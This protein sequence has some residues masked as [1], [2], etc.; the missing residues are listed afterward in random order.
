MRLSVS[1]RAVDIMGVAVFPQNFVDLTSRR[2]EPGE[3]G[4]VHFNEQC[5]GAVGTGE[6][7]FGPPKG[8]DLGTLDIQ[9]DH[10]R[11]GKSTFVHQT[12]K[13]PR[14]H[15]NALAFAASHKTRAVPVSTVGEEMHRAI[16]VA[17]GNWLDCDHPIR[18]E[19]HIDIQPLPERW[20][21]LERHRSTDLSGVQ[22][23]HA[24]VC[25]DIEQNV[26]AVKIVKH[27]CQIFSFSAVADNTVMLGGVAHLESHA[28]TF[29]LGDGSDKGNSA[30]DEPPSNAR[31]HALDRVH[32]VPL[33]LSSQQ[34]STGGSSSP[35]A[36]WLPMQ[37]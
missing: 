11:P 32:A 2:P 16:R 17:D 24:D 19:P 21:G 31:R 3:V 15:G 37:P 10:G 29:K 7:P 18:V 4:V 1:F 28:G 23:D 12:V 26:I 14:G 20:V 35:L 6:E 36:T 5:A 13:G 8:E 27:R 33:L 34:H 22:G 30:L 9:F 25:A